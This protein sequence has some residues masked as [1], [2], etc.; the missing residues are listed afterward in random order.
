MHQGQLLHLR[1]SIS[2]DQPELHDAA[3]LHRVPVVEQRKK[4]MHNS[5]H[6]AFFSSPIKFISVVR[7]ITTPNLFWAFALKSCP[8]FI[9]AAHFLISTLHSTHCFTSFFSDFTF[10]GH[11]FCLN[12]QLEVLFWLEP[13]ADTET[14]RLGEGKGFIQ[15]EPDE[16]VQEGN[17]DWMMRWR[18]LWR[19]SRHGDP[20]H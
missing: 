17:A 12:S 18:E 14:T 4:D 19:L 6:G 13:R 10:R 20:G 16:M 1:V 15:E 8:E 3:R 5:T 9:A 7:S 11:G 2:I